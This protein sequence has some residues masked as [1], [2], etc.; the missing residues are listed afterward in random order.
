MKETIRGNWKKW[1]VNAILNVTI[2]SMVAGGIVKCKQFEK[3]ASNDELEKS[4]KLVMTQQAEAMFINI[5]EHDA[6]LMAAKKYTDN[7]IAA[8]ESKN[9]LKFENI[10]EKQ[11]IIITNLKTLINMGEKRMDVNEQRLERLE[12]VYILSKKV[13]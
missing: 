7:Q 9:A 10:E 5:Q 2:A 3:M 8:S 13:N 6:I 11:D 1:I 12:D 4:I